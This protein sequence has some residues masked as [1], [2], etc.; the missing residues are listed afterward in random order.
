MK[1]SAKLNRQ[2]FN[3]Q[4]FGE[5]INTDFTQLVQQPDPTFFDIDLA[6]IEDFFLLY[7]KFF[8]E[9]PKEG[10]TNSHEYLVRESSDYIG[11]QQSNEEIQALLEEI[12]QLRQENLELREQQANII[13]TRATTAVSSGGAI[14]TTTNTLRG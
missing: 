2:V 3:K 7:N 6:T 5:T 14:S 4:K 8:F 10:Q 1:I 11:F 13:A 12:S 9:I